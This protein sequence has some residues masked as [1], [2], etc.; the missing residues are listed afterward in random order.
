[1]KAKSIK[2]RVKLHRRRKAAGRAV[3]RIEVDDAAITDLLIS[4][5]FLPMTSA[6]DPEKT[7]QALERLIESLAVADLHA[8]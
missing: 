8:A 1:M 2:E 7:R 3:Y 4:S 6:D 5:G